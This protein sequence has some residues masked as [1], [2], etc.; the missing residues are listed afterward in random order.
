MCLIWCRKNLQA[1]GSFPLNNIPFQFIQGIL[2]F[3]MFEG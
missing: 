3:I 1:P 2:I